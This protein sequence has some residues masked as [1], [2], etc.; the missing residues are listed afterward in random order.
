MKVKPTEIAYSVGFMTCGQM[1]GIVLGTGMSGALFINYSQQALVKVFPN[2]SAGE[3]SDAIAGIASQLI[4]SS[5][6][7]QKAQ[8]IHGITR[9]IQLAYVPIIA[10]GAICLVCSILMKREKVFN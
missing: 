5:S 10:A 3:I 8:A 7:D 1:L 4:N 2:A 9:A 6:A